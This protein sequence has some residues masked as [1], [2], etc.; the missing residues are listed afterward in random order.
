MEDEDPNGDVGDSISVVASTSTMRR[1]VAS[2]R[3]SEAVG[4][5]PYVFHCWLCGGQEPLT[6]KWLGR[7]LDTLCWSAIRCHH[8]LLPDAAAKTSDRQ[9][10]LHDVDKHGQ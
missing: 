2:A 4:D 9:R 1:H 3:G 5:D 7:L 8:R 10:M 6:T